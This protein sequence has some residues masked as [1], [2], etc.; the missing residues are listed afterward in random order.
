MDSGMKRPASL[1]LDCTCDG[2]VPWCAVCLIHAAF[3]L[4]AIHPDSL[5]IGMLKRHIPRVTGREASILLEAARRVR[6]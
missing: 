5:S 4:K 1:R 6:S 3:T 2:K